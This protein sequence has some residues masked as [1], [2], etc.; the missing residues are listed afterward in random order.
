MSRAA[1]FD[2][3]IPIRYRASGEAGWGEG[4]TE[5]ISR[6]GVL[7]RAKQLLGVGTPID[8]AFALP[9]EISGEAHAEVTCHGR[10]VRH[11]VAAN[12]GTLPGLAA[13]ILN[14]RFLRTKEPP[15]A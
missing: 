12:A 11:E 5:N 9:A 3:R 7:F 1:R 8:L 15:S 13:T 4:T 2:L 14:Y 10:I 6:S